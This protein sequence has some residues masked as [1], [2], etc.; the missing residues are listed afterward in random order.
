MVNPLLCF[1]DNPPPGSYQVDRSFKRTQDKVEIHPPRT[2]SGRKKQGTFQS[3][4]S[5]FAPPRDV[6]IEE[7]DPTYPG[8]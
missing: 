4:S 3:S 5:R 6:V 2:E 1:Q 8:Q 7:A